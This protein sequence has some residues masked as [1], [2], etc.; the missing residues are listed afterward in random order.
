MTQVELIEQVIRKLALDPTPET[1]LRIQTSAYVLLPTA[2]KVVSHRA[3]KDA[4]YEG[5]QKD[6][7][8]TPTA[9]VVDLTALSGII[10]DLARSR[11][12]VTS[13]NAPVNAVDSLET[14]VDGGLSADVPLYA[15]DGTDLRF[16]DTAG[17]MGTFVTPIKIKSSYVLALSDVPTQY[18]ALL[19]ETLAGLLGQMASEARAHEMAGDSRA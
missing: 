6:F 5:L 11:V 12:R 4:G 1:R 10:F 13:S 18:E 14:L 15:Q 8:V 17:A 16:R 7:P 2:L 19:V 9:G 3:A